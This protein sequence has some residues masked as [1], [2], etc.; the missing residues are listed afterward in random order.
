MEVTEVKNTTNAQKFSDDWLQYKPKFRLHQRVM[1]THGVVGRV[2]GIQQMESGPW[3]YQ[4]LTPAQYGVTL[5]WWDE[6]Q[7]N[8]IRDRYTVILVENGKEVEGCCA[9]TLDEAVDDVR[10]YVEEA[11]RQY[12]EYGRRMAVQI[13]CCNTHDLE[14]SV[15]TSYEAAFSPS[16]Y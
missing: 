11:Y 2:S 1:T 5:S 15:L 8:P 4:I 13:I 12:Q 16:L 3:R 14:D 10:S 7:L 9:G 6:E